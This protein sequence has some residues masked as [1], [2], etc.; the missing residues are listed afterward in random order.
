MM[1]ILDF[2]LQETEGK[3]RDF[4][5]RSVD[6]LAINHALMSY[7]ISSVFP[8]FGFS[9]NMKILKSSFT[10]FASNLFPQDSKV[11]QDHLRA[12]INN[13]ADELL[14][15][16]ES[17]QALV[18]RIYFVGGRQHE[19]TDVLSTI[20]FFSYFLFPWFHSI[21]Q[22]LILILSSYYVC[23]NLL[24]SCMTTSSNL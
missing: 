24:S 16:P 7:F 14:S 22:T 18:E 20:G 3:G 19:L 10:M 1:R 8:S 4:L 12:T 13:I 23:L 9:K 2:K 21:C 17:K 5:L 6:P 15:Q 11:Y